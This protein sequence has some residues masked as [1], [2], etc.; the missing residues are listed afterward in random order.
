VAGTSNCFRLYIPSELLI[1]CSRLLEL[2]LMS[3]SNVGTVDRL[4]NEPE[5][6][7]CKLRKAQKNR[8]FPDTVRPQ[9]SAPVMAPV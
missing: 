9:H 8:S 2:D 7:L 5:Y 1:N 4:R 3:S 6:Y